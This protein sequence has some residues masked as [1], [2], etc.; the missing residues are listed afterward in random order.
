MT[1]LANFDINQILKMLPHRYPFLLV[2]RI[3]EL[4]F[5]KSVK[6]LKNVTMNEPHFTGHFPEFPVMPGVLILEA[7]AQTAAL[8]TYG[9]EKFDDSVYFF[10]GI[11]GARFKKPVTPGDQLIMN[12]SV[13]RY[14]GGIWKFKTYATVN[15]VVVTEADL[16]C[17]IRKKEA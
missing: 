7:L 12:A 8:L 1:E 9:G 6:A 17:T 13:D 11:D 2:D 5:G 15:D 14:K 10:V 4:E 16:M 3:L